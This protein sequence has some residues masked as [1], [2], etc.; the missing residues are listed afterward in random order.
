MNSGKAQY[1]KLVDLVRLICAFMIVLIHMGF[2][3]ESAFIPCI[4]RQA[5]PFFFLVSGFFFYRR[6]DRSDSVFQF[7]C[8]YALSIALIYA[9][10]MILWMPYI[11]SSV[12]S[13]HPGKSF[14]YL[15][16]VV[17]RR[18]FLAGIAPY[19]YLLVL[20]EGSLLLG[21]I[22]H[23]KKKWIGWLLCIGGLIL[24]AI[25]NMNLNAGIGRLIH[26]CFY[27]VF[28]WDCNVIMIGFP[29][30]FLGAVIS[31]HEDIL[32]PKFRPAAAL[33]YILAFVSAFY[34]HTFNKS[35][36]GIPFGVIQAIL[37]F[38]FCILPS[39]LC[40]N[41][42]DPVCRFAR[43]L[44]SVIFLTHTFFLMVF[45]Y[46]LHIWNTYLRLLLT[47]ACGLILLLIIEKM[48]RKRIN[49]IFLIKSQ[50]KS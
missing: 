31:R 8:S 7:S 32:Q 6:A 5:V 14:L 21:M 30:L 29:L 24:G 2:G 47:A 10:W 20:A 48:D 17:L 36:F 12:V 39:R 27:T 18:V 25:Y 23:F 43:N 37:L 22:L 28:S 50:G 4:T 26:Q 34:V 42:P 15:A 33:L 49:R 1:Y 16:F 45:G 44:S 11:I 13:A 41:I 38:I 3:N 9:V 35:L 46:V 40:A 19:W